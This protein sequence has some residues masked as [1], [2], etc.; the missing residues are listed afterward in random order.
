MKSEKEKMLAG[1]LH[2]P[3]DP[4]LVAE[5]I[6]ARDLYLTLNNTREDQQI[7]RARLLRE[8]LGRETDVWI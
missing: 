6:R 7:E 1:E 4:Q 3:L 2:D 5:R 8:L